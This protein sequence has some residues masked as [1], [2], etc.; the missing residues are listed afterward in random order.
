M[1]TR[2]TTKRST[3]RGRGPSGARPGSSCSRPRRSTPGGATSWRAAGRSFPG[4]GST[5][6]TDSTPTRGAPRWRTSSRGARSCWSTTSCWVPTTRRGARPARRSPTGSTASPFTSRTT[7]SCSPRCRARRWRRCRPTS[8][9]WAGASPGRPRSEAT[10]TTTSGWGSP[11]SS[12]VARGGV[13]LHAAGRE[14]GGASPAVGR[15]A[16][17]IA[18]G[19]GI[20]WPTF[21]RERPG[22]S[23]FVLEDGAV[24]HTYSAYARGLDGLWG[25]YQWLDRAPRG[26]NES[27]LWWRRHDEYDK[28]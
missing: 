4:F 19:V 17:P 1:A 14:G 24:Y 21:F 15:S 12:S 10:S 8:G 27:G 2:A 6:S 13:Q 26:R 25:M 3:S 7:T 20:D 28:R 18:A 22:M 23:A 11:K 9:A 16:A 5:R